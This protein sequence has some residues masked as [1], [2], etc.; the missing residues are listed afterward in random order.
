[1][2]LIPSPKR[3]PIM[4]SQT[5]Q[6]AVQTVA[7]NIGDVSTVAT[8]VDAGIMDSVI[9]LG[10]SMGIVA[11]NEEAIAKLALIEHAL[12][13]LDANMSNLTT[14]ASE[15]AKVGNV[16]LNMSTLLVIHS[17][18]ADLLNIEGS[19]ANIDLV[20]AN[21]ANVSIVSGMVPQL[22]T[23][24]SHMADI[25]FLAQY[26]SELTEVFN[27][28]TG[29]VTLAGHATE[30]S[31]IVDN[32]PAVLDAATVVGQLETNLQAITLVGNNVDAKHAEVVALEASAAA[33]A[34]S[35][36]QDAIS[37]AADAINTAQDVLS[38]EA[39]KVAANTSK[40]NAQTSE[41]NAKT[42][43]LA[44]AASESIASSA[45]STAQSSEASAL[46]AESAAVAAAAAALISE[47]N[48]KDSEFLTA[49][50]KNR[51][52]Q[53]RVQT[54]ADAASTL[55]NAQAAQAS[56]TSA[57]QSATDAALYATAISNGVVMM[58]QWDASGGTFPPMPAGEPNEPSHVYRISHE[59]TLGGTLYRV[60]DEVI[61]D[62]SANVW[63]K[64]DNTQR[65]TSVQGLEGDVVITPNLIGLGQVNNTAD[66]DKPIS[67][68]TQTALNSKANTSG[69]YGGLRAQATTKGDVGLSQVDNT[70]DANKPVSIAQANA[71]ATKEPAFSKNTA[72]NK[73]FGNSAG[74]VAEGDHS[75]TPSSLGAAPAQHSHNATELTSGILPSE[76]FNDTAHGNRGG[77]STHS[78]AT[79]NAHGFMSASDK[80][81]LDTIETGATGDQSPA[82]IMTAIKS[83]D[84]AG[85]GLD[86]DTVDGYHAASFQLATGNI[87]ASRIIDVPSTWTIDTNT[88]RPIK[89]TPVNNDTS[90]SISSNW[91]YT[92]AASSTAHP[93]D[94]RNQIAGDYTTA[95]QVDASIATHNS[96]STHP[97][98]SVSGNDLFITF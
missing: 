6:N 85:S 63:F 37:T 67:S 73:N 86:A 78:T 19:L 58:G 39:A 98:M 24:V 22:A 62:T 57:A 9:A 17:R 56:A 29:I 93:R 34:T 47:T 33:Y 80:L 72:F 65:V 46:G 49:A 7:E 87:S 12:S 76:R 74:Q 52:A 59:G 43:E 31:T 53:D 26:A 10:S 28:I 16:S 18:M 83:Q 82:E 35:A 11:S 68:A 40:M 60:D 44:A 64:R 90:S 77:G 45:A 21:D 94:T 15:I 42:S 23:V 41:D 8:A 95:A 54:T 96:S 70:S 50:D 89:Q 69:I 1:M 5:Q 20:A 88:W 51:T 14:V 3:N 84:G 4:V 48:A 36:G 91:A 71:L 79:T 97:S 27:N 32:L 75:H 38:T 25:H 81:K 55:A 61:W 66:S 30:I 2:G 13:N 92:H